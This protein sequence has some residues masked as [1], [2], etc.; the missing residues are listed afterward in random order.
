MI[1]V[2]G[3]IV[4]Q[5]HFPDHTLFIKPTASSQLVNQFEWNYE[6]D[7]ELFTL[8]CLRKHYDKGAAYLTLKYVPHA[9]MDR[10]KN[11]EDVFTLKYFCEVINSLDFQRVY[12]LDVHSNVS[13]ALLNNVKS[14]PVAPFIQNAVLNIPNDP[15]FYFP[16]EGAMKRYSEH[17]PGAYAFGIKKRDWATGKIQGIQIQNAE[18]VS[19]KDILIVDDICSKGGTF[20]YSAKALKEAGAAN[21]YLYV[22]HLE[23]SVLEGDLWKAM[24]D[25]KLIKQIFTANPLFDIGKNTDLIRVV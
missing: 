16:D 24:I 21:I 19:G 8:I 4:E 23:E 5:N 13:L 12:V 3:V 10:V 6:N 20:Y 9:R 7:S 17:A 2:N 18:L 11:P 25:G 22:T 1:K 15:V 14:V